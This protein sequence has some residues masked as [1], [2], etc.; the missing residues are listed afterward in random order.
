MK[1]R[2]S[3]YTVG[4]NI[5]WCCHYGVARVG[6]DLVTESPSPLR[7]TVWRFLYKLKFP[8]DP[9]IPL[10]STHME[11]S[12]SKKYMNLKVH[13]SAINNRS[14]INNSQDMEDTCPLRDGQIKMWCM[15][16]M[17]YWCHKNRVK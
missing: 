6:H 1:K 4:G 12:N 8:Y 14:T 3:S 15:Y 5:I 17:K 13:R 2:E 11:K 7:K 10:L 9:A 16:M